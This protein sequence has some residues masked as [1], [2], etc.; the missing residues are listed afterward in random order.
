MKSGRQAIGRLRNQDRSEKTA[1]VKKKK[2]K[3]K[4]IYPVAIKANNRKN[5]FSYRETTGKF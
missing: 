1:G 2:T 3:K 5:K 4:L